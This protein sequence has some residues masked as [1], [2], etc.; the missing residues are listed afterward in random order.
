MGCHKLNAFNYLQPGL[1]DRKGFWVEREYK[2]QRNVMLADDK[3]C[4][5]FEENVIGRIDESVPIFWNVTTG[6]I[7]EQRVDTSDSFRGWRNNPRGET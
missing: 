6:G 2:V 3:K 7:S 1:E 4:V 5:A